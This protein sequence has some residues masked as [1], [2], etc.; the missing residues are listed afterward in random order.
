MFQIQYMGDKLVAAGVPHQ[1]ISELFDL[2]NTCWSANLCKFDDRFF[3]FSTAVGILTNGIPLWIL[4][5]PR[6]LWIASKKNLFHSSL[7][8]LRHAEFIG[9]GTSM[10]SC[11]YGTAP[12]NKP[13]Y[14][15]RPS[16]VCTHRLTSHWRLVERT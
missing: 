16:T 15:W 10:T 13:L 14:F 9:T 7:G 6:Y 3:K 2:R 8:L 1:H 11:A 4:S 5:L 12:T